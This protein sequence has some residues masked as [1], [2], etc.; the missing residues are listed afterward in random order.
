[1]FFFSPFFIRSDGS[2]AL[3]F[4]WYGIFE[5]YGRRRRPAPISPPDKEAPREGIPLDTP[6]LSPHNAPRQATF[7][8][9]PS[10]C[11]PVYHQP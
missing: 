4:G 10:R 7:S 8:H 5:G 1:V 3:S 6:F 2:D 9:P 11:R